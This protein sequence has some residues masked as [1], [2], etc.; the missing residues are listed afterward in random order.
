LLPYKI[1]SILLSFVRTVTQ[2][3]Q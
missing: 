2:N 1:A 3:T